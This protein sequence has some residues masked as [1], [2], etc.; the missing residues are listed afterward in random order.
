MFDYY[1][2]AQKY[3]ETNMVE[4]FNKPWKAG[5]IWPRRE[6]VI[7]SSEQYLLHTCHT[8]NTLDTTVTKDIFERFPHANIYKNAKAP[9]L[10]GNV[11]DIMSERKANM[12][13]LGKYFY[14]YYYY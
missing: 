7:S 2:K 14:Y 12:N 4:I 5:E 6:F 9:N 13:K 11:R 10:T 8:Y 3:N 1:L